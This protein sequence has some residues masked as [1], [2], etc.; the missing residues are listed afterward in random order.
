MCSSDL[1][2]VPPGFAVDFQRISHPFSERQTL[3]NGMQVIR[4][5][6]P[7]PFPPDSSTTIT[8]PAIV[9][10]NPRIPELLINQCD[11]ASATSDYNSAND[12][13]EDSVLIVPKYDLRLAYSGEKDKII[14]PNSEEL[15]TLEISNHSTVRVENFNL[16]LTLDD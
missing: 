9:T 12:H 14:A 11:I 13:A 8:I 6:F 15:Y 2:S 1:D 3:P 4:W 16:T 5:I 10:L 7:G